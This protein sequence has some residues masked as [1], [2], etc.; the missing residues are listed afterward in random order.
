[1]RQNMVLGTKAVAKNIQSNF[2]Q[3][4][5]KNRTTSYLPLIFS[6]A[7]AEMLEKQNYILHNSHFFPEHLRIAQN[8]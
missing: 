8:G 3:K 7:L 6:S 4:C 5:W 1:M 2:L